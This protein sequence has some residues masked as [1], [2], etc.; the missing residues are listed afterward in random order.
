MRALLVLLLLS[1]GCGSGR[2]LYQ[3]DWPDLNEA[4]ADS[5]LAYVTEPKAP[6]CQWHT[7]EAHALAVE[8]GFILECEEGAR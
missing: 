1:T 7:P 3:D 5:N 6:V 4:R 2:V 8:Q